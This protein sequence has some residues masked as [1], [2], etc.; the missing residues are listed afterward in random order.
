MCIYSN[1]KRSKEVILSIRTKNF[2]QADF[3]IDEY[4]VSVSAAAPKIDSKF[5]SKHLSGGYRNSPH[6]RIPSFSNYPYERAPYPDRYYEGGRGSYANSRGP[7]PPPFRG[8]PIMKE[9]WQ[10]ERESIDRYAFPSSGGVGG[11]G[12]GNLFDIFKKEQILFVSLKYFYNPL[13]LEKYL[14]ILFLFF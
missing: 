13:I 12:Y 5:E 8:H 3:I 14:K 2:R 7:P 6:S 9:P 11:Y 1:S 10:H 4:S